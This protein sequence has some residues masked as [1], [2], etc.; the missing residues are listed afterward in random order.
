MS[1]QPN[2]IIIMADQLRRDALGPYTPNINALA[3]E[4]TVFNRC[5]CASPLCVPAR[6]AFFTGRY[7]NETGSLINPWVPQDYEHG[8]VE[9]GIPNLYGLLEDEWDSWHTGKQHL[10]TA[11]EIDKQPNSKTKWNT[12]EKGYSK[13][14]QAQDLR[15]PGG[16][17]YRGMMPELVSGL[18]T[19]MTTYSIPTT[20]CYPHGFDNF[21]DGY[22]TKTSLQAIRERDTSR[23]FMLNAMYIAPH[24]PLEIPEPWYSL[25][26]SE[27]IELPENVGRWG[28]DQSPLQLWNLTGLLGTRYSREDWQ[29]VWRVYLGLVALFDH[30]VGMVLDELKTQGL[31]DESLIILTADH[32]EMLGSH[33]LWQKMCN[34]EES[35]HV[36]L[37]VRTPESMRGTEANESD[38]LVSH[39]DIMPTIL[40]YIGHEIPDGVTG[41]SLR[42]AINGGQLGRDR[43]FCQFD[44]NGALGNFS[45]TVVCG[46]YKLNADMFKGETFFE[47]F[48]LKNDPQEMTNLAFGQP[49]RVAELL[50]SLIGWM[51]ETGDL[52]NL[53][54]ED[55]KVFRKEYEAFRERAARKAQAFNRI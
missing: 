3:Q 5:Y 2:I 26:K 40:D 32:G 28:Q 23:P 53:S 34:Y 47:L 29:E 43:V 15:G 52:Q 24:P 14:L 41:L 37:Y 51:R 36:P 11:E 48:D 17:A 30:G 7:C 45:R 10:Y 27:D 12:L 39:I 8:V 20:G 6:G 55:Y 9:A 42:S 54:G 31:Y 22:I 21:F 33:R 35:A 50:P 46:D 13:H 19:R 38:E 44:G 25:V 1:D 18:F 49:E 16:D 4:S